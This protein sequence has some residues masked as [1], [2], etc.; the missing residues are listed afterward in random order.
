[1]SE[2]VIKH[3][4]TVL[5]VQHLVT[6]TE[7]ARILRFFKQ[8]KHADKGYHFELQD[9]GGPMKRA[10]ELTGLEAYNLRAYDGSDR[11]AWW[12]NDAYLLR[13]YRTLPA[14]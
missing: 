9:L 11:S 2:V 6:L 7:A 1:M 4:Q 5:V 3:I 12:E 13:V 10:V 14:R 8:K